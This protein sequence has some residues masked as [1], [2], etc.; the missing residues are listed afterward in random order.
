[1]A[2]WRLRGKLACAWMRTFLAQYKA[3]HRRISYRSLRTRFSL[4]APVGAAKSLQNNKAIPIDA[5]ASATSSGASRKKGTPA[6]TPFYKYQGAKPKPA[7]LNAKP[8]LSAGP[9]ADSLHPLRN[10]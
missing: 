5:H 2:A 9:G 8:P 1:M 4:E 10:S 3:K 7:P 6:K